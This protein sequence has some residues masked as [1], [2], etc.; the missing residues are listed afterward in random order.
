MAAAESLDG[1]CQP[2]YGPAASD[3][4]RRGGHFNSSD[5]TN[6]LRSENFAHALRKAGVGVAV[7]ED[8]VLW[9]ALA[10]ATALA[11]SA[12]FP[13]AEIVKH[14]AATVAF[15]AVGMTI[16]PKLFQRFSR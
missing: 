16:A 4:D 8:T 6:F 2:T 13:K 7:I 1:K 11:T 15:F 10:I 12:M 5:L 3:W 14:V 9:G